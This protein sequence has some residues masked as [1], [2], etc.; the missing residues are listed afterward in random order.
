MKKTDLLER[1]L[2][3]TILTGAVMFAAP[4]YAQDVEAQDTDIEM[5]GDEERMVVTGSRLVSSTV[6]S[7]NPV[8]QVDARDLQARG[9]VLIE[10]FINT[11]PQVL[12]AQTTDV[13]NGA[14]GTSSLNL[15]G[16]GADRTLVLID[17][18]RLPYG[19]PQFSAANVDLVPTALI[20]RVDVVT[21]GASAVYGSD[22]VGGVVNFILKDDFEGLQ[23]DVQGGFNWDQNDNEFAQAVLASSLQPV[24]SDSVIDGFNTVVSATFGANTADDRG[25]V[26]AFFQYLRQGESLQSDHDISGCAL[27]ASS[28]QFA[29]DGIACVGSGN[30]RRFIDAGNTFLE[31]D[32]TLVPFVG[33]PLQTFNFGPFN[34]FQRPVER[35]TIYAKAHY[36]ILENMRGYIDVEFQNNTTDSQ[37]APSASFNRPFRINCDNPLLQ[38]GLG[39]NGDGEGT[40]FDLSNCQTDANGDVIVEDIAFRTSHRNVEGGPRRSTIDLSTWRVVGGID[41]S[42]FN[43]TVSYDLHAQFARTS[44]VDISRNDLNFNRVQEA[45]FVIEDENGNLVC[46]DPDARAAGCVPWNIFQRGADGSTGVSQEAVDYIQGV[47]ITTGFTE[48]VVIGGTIQADGTDYGMISPFAEDGLQI[49]GGF[50]IR[51][52]SLESIPDDISQISA[53]RGLTGTGGG[54][55][56]VAGEV[57]VAE[58]FME[59]RIPLI[60][61]WPFIQE[62]AINGAYRR[63]MYTTDGNGVTNSF[64]T[65]TYH[66]G[67]TWQVNDEIRLRGQ[68]QRALRA[69]NVIELFTGQNTGLFDANAG[70]NGLF[71]PC[72]GDFDPN[73]DIPEP[74]ATEAECAFTGVTAA[75]YGTI[76]DNEAGQLNTV[77]GGNPNLNPELSETITAGIVYQPAFVPG[78]TVAVDYFLIDGADFIGSIPGQNI[79]DNCVASGNPTFCNLI[80]RD[81]F[82]SLFIANESPTGVGFAGVFLTNTNVAFNKTSGLDFQVDYVFDT[83]DLGFGDYGSVIVDYA[84]TYVRKLETVPFAGEEPFECAGFTLGNCANPTP[85]YRHVTNFTWE[86]PYAL[87]LRLSWRYIGSVENEGAFTAEIDSG[88]DAEQYLDVAAFY[89][90]A[91]S[92][93]FRFGINNLLDNDPPIST[94]VGTAPGNGNTFPGTYDALGRYVFAGVTFTR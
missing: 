73:T 63:S 29:V 66:A 24:P 77:T 12:A 7:N 51:G 32:G 76:L 8:L 34:A 60:Q 46:R 2:C 72:A 27:G 26:T 56:P 23:I 25:N 1:L 87:D 78:L 14:S 54:T 48:Q 67:L 53:G 92:V 85:K 81:E 16:L 52:D 71:D 86:T 31:E 3:S 62:L 19:S 36:D 65:N 83:A 82:G 9:T 41:G 37:I 38:N 59:A 61:D 30:F 43:D 94:S 84:A 13:A 10:D 15:R 17:G 90:P 33:G 49:L 74:A 6:T 35:F 28:S 4:V 18:K 20:E 5:E 42:L 55:L 75:Q 57:R 21:G 68:F 39:P 93:T 47:G 11:L 50:E 22:A 69:P 91:D 44:I 40:F 79:L 45:V 88:F 70:A 89:S 80:Q 58:A 64:D